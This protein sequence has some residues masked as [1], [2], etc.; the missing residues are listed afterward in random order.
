MDRELLAVGERIRASMPNGMRQREL[1]ARVG[2]TPDALSRALNGQRGFSILELTRISDDLQ[3]GLSWLIT[4]RPDPHKVTF[5]ARHLW[6]NRSRERSNPGQ[7]DDQDVLDEIAG[8]YRNAYLDGTP[9]STA[10]PADPADLRPALGPDFV[11]HFAELAEDKLGVDVVRIGGVSTDYSMTIGQRAVVV[12][13]T[14]P[15]WFRS[16]WLLAHELGHLALG[17]HS[18]GAPTDAA[19]AAAN[20]F[21]AELLMPAATFRARSW[22]T[23]TVEDL[24]RFLWSAGVSFRRWNAR[25]SSLG[26]RV[27]DHLGTVMRQPDAHRGAAARIHRAEVAERQQAAAALDACHWGC[28]LG[29]GGRRPLTWQNQILPRWSICNAAAARRRPGLRLQSVLR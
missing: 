5:A 22:Q 1:A 6:D 7:D 19:E 11:R 3:T 2:M 12:L 28:W 24:A 13:T 14:T 9:A 26:I 10:L 17:H 21:A 23:M 25:M 15:N 27:P 18:N 4:G 29:P 20:A 16:N 8:L